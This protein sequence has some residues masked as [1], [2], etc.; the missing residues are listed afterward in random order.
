MGKAKINFYQNKFVAAWNISKKT[1]N[2][3]TIFQAKIRKSI[4]A[5]KYQTINQPLLH[6]KISQTVL[7]NILLVFCWNLLHKF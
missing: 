2:L 6:P 4:F 1:W 5:P 7:M 3:I